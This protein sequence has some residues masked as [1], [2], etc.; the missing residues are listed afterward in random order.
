MS[1]HHLFEVAFDVPKDLAVSYG[2]EHTDCIGP[3]EVNFAG[4]IFHEGAHNDD[5][6]I[7]S[8]PY[9]HKQPEPSGL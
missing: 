4:H 8:R 2:T 1:V 3:V 7:R 9:L 6:L 5:H